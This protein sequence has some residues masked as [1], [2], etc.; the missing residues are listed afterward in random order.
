M[1][2]LIA[3]EFADYALF[4]YLNYLEYKEGI[5]MGNTAEMYDEKNKEAKENFLLLQKQYNF[6]LILARLYMEKV[7]TKKVCFY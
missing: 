7:M 4:P 3:N 1:G 2:V 5:V 6:M